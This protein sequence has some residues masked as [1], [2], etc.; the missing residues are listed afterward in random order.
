M[1]A[2]K[3][4]NKEDIIDKCIDIIRESSIDGI[5]TRRIAKELKCSTQPIYYIY[6][7]K[8]EMLKDTFKKISEIFDE[9]IFKRNYNIPA[10]KDIGKNYIEF[11]KNEPNLFKLMFN[12]DTNKYVLDF[13]D[14][15]ESNE[16]IFKTVSNQTGLSIE[17]SKKFHLKM[18]LYVNGIANLVSNNTCKFTDDEIDE[19]LKEQYLSMLL[20]EINKGN[21]K[22]EV[23]DKTINFNLERK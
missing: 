15:N 1:G 19:L 21:I 16:N 2:V 6:S 4:I 18:W 3:K 14:L 9:Y 22:K 23:Y 5:N 7:N 13:I 12:S 10:Y 11:A 8:D 17:E 20:Y